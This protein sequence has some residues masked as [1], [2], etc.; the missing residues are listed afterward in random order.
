MESKGKYFLMNTF[1]KKNEL[2]L[3]ENTIDDSQN[4]KFNTICNTNHVNTNIE[5][6]INNNINNTMIINDARN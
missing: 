3:K 1:G 2:N 6:T 4:R 5:S